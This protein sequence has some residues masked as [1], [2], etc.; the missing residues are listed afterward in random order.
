[1]QDKVTYYPHGY[2]GKQR[3]D[4]YKLDCEGCEYTLLA[5]CLGAQEIIMEYH[6]SPRPLID[7]LAAAGYG[8]AVR[9][10]ILYA[11]KTKGAR[12]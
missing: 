11:R 1:M 8:I 3:A 6:A 10:R 9:G 2:D 12:L 5:K 7:Q 4:V